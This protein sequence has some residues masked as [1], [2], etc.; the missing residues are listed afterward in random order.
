MKKQPQYLGT[1]TKKQVKELPYGFT[2]IYRTSPKWFKIKITKKVIKNNRKKTQGRLVENVGN[3]GL[4]WL[5]LPF[6]TKAFMAINAY[7]KKQQ[8]SK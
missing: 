4:K 7:F 1:L 3:Q 5:R 2:P 8:E 6:I